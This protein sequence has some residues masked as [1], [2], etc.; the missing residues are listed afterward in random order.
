M[1]GATEARQLEITS[2]YPMDKVILLKSGSFTLSASSPHLEV[3]P[4]DL[5]FTPLCSGNW[6]FVSD[7]STQY[8]FAIGTFPSSNPGFLFNQVANV[9]ADTD[10][11]YVSMDNIQAT[12]FT[13]Y[14]RVFGLQPS[15]DDSYI[16]PISTLGD[17]FIINTGSNYSK[18]LLD[19]LI[20]L[21]ATGASGQNVLISHTAGVTPQVTGWVTY[22][23]YNGVRMVQCVH[24][25]G[26]S[27]GA[28]QGVLILVGD[29]AIAFVI[30]PFTDAHRAYYRI[31]LDE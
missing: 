29:I 7:F 18:V 24:P 1:L 28:S 11:V 19:G 20:D 14:Y 27:N 31:Y 9:F 8:E 22:N 21:P 25:V 6:S 4:H 15:D 2:D 30:P 23:T 16:E 12:T 3:I 13:I 26:T 17:N 10:N 5:D